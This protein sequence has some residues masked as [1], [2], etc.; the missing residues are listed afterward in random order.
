MLTDQTSLED[1]IL[2]LAG[3]SNI[4]P[5]EPFPTLKSSDYSLIYSFSKQIGRKIGFTDRQYELAKNKVDDYQELFHFVPNLEEVKN[6]T[7]L[8]IREIDR[9][10]WIKIEYQDN[11]PVIA[12]RFT[13]QKKLIS[14]IEGI[15]SKIKEKTDYDKVNKIHYFAYSERNLFEIVEAFKEN[16]FQLD[17]PVQ[18]IYNKLLLLDPNEHLPGMYDLKI[19]N[20]HPT[21]VEMIHAELGKLSKDNVLLYRDRAFKYGLQAFD[22]IE[23]DGSLEYKIAHRKHPNVAID[24]FKWSI[25]TLLLSLENLKRFPVLIL[26]PQLTCHDVIVTVQEYVRNLIPPEDVSV[27]FRLDN[28]G[29]GT[30]FNNYIKDQHIN[31]KVDKNTKIVYSLDNKIPKPLLTSTWSPQTIIVYGTTSGYVNTRKV[32]DCFSD[33]DL[34]LYYGDQVGAGRSQYY[35][36]EFDK[37]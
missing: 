19:K 24:D 20:L 21:G 11:N 34:I 3:T 33:K 12:V 22:A 1:L 37:I 9:A 18:E 5:N 23:D 17:D 7:R 35:R 28:Q 26:V 30:L 16:N 4:A 8:P 27:V 2:F 14:A 13:F 29:D 6:T 36:R 32:L 15:R 10:R 31:N 25:D